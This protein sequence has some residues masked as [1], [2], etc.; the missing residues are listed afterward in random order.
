M[1]EFYLG[2]SEM[3]FRHRGH[4]V[5]QVQLAKRVDAVPVTRDY[6]GEAERSL[7]RPR[8]RVA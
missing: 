7:N 4:F 3:T 6:L 5:F 1:F 2:I 8:R